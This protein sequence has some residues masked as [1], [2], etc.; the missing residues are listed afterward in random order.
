M[1]DVRRRAAACQKHMRLSVWGA[2][3][4]TSTANITVNVERP[5]KVDNDND[6]CVW[7]KL[8]SNCNSKSNSYT[9][10]LPRHLTDETICHLMQ[11]RHGKRSTLADNGNQ[12][13]QGWTEG[14]KVSLCCLT[15][16]VSACAPCV[17]RCIDWTH[18]EPSWCKIKK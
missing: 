17:D 1:N 18:T 5:L 6:C 9:V 11:T 7:R 16:R 15:M 3:D 8:P 14:N 4:S 10:R 2:H 13:V 12:L